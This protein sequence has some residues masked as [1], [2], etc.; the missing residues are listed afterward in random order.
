MMN[1]TIGSRT[2]RVT[3]EAEIYEL[4]FFLKIQAA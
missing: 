1:I 2:F 4:C 3:T